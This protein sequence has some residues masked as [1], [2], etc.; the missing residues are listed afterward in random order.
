MFLAT[1]TICSFDLKKAFSFFFLFFYADGTGG[2][3]LCCAEVV[4]ILR[5]SCT[6]CVLLYSDCVVPMLVSCGVWCRHDIL[7]RLMCVCVG[8]EVEWNDYIY[9]ELTLASSY[10]FDVALSIVLNFVSVYK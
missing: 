7:F 3:F 8:V 4:V 5:F 2:Q 10:V 1:L 6:F 9:G